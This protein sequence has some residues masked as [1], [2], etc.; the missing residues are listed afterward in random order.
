MKL[1]EIEKTLRAIANR[2]SSISEDI[3]K[4]KKEVLQEVKKVDNKVI[5][6]DGEVK[7]GFKKVHERLD[8]IGLQVA[9]NED[10]TPSRDEHDALEKR[11][12]KLEHH[13]STT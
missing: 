5:K 7:Q 3:L 13:V 1:T 10:E 12:T 4:S 6:L 11:V 2:Q 9:Y 8:K